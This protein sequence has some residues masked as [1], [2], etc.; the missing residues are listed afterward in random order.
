MPNTVASLSI[1]TV[2]GA[3]FPVS[4]LIIELLENPLR[5]ANSSC[6]QPLDFLYY[7]N[8]SPNIFTTPYIYIIV[9]LK[10]SKN[11]E[12]QG[13]SQEQLTKISGLSRSSIISIS[14]H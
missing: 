3:R 1:S 14:G 12:K 10:K 11:Q 6:F 2:R 5:S 4:Q 7:F 9:L 13:L 8:L